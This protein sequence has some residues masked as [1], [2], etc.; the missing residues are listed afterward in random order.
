VLVRVRDAAGE[1]QISLEGLS[2][3]PKFTPDGKALCYRIFRGALDPYGGS[4]ELRVA[5]L[6]SGRSEPLLP[7][8]AV[9]GLPGRGYDIS[10]DGRWVVASATDREGRSRLW[11]AA[12][13]R[14]SPP[15][16][17][18]NAEGDQPLFGTGGEIFFRSIESASAFI[19]RIDQ[20]GTNGRKVSQQAISGLM[21]VSWDGNWLV[22]R[23]VGQG[24]GMTTAVSLRDGRSLPIFEFRDTHFSWSPDRILISIPVSSAG[25]YGL[26][27]KT[28]VI[29]LAAGQTFPSIPAGGFRSEAEIAKLPG[30]T[31]IDAYDVA[32]GPT[33]NV[34]AYSRQT[35]QRNLYRIPI[36]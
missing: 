21:G 28:Y 15:R 9:A 3:D 11:L 10:R 34:Y 36:P 33:P 23:V 29:P 20:D 18:P 19:Y 5:D 6:E 25:S 16:Q 22:A 8:L 4:S 35:V 30:A 27:G 31:V 24:E 32:A 7:G 1:R 12:L 14:Q 13:D 17:I 26:A 2:Y